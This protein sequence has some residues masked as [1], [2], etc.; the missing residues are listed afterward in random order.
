MV[1]ILL[2]DKDKGEHKTIRNLLEKLPDIDSELHCLTDYGSGLQELLCGQ[3]DLCF[4]ANDLEENRG[5]RFLEDSLAQSIEVPIVILSSGKSRKTDLEALHFGAADFLVKGRIQPAFLQRSIRYALLR[6]ENLR[7]ERQVETQAQFKLSTQ[8]LGEL[9]T[10]L[11]PFLSDALNKLE[12]ATSQNPNP[13]LFSLA[14]DAYRLVRYLEDRFESL[15][16][17]DE[18]F[19]VQQLVLETLDKTRMKFSKDL[20]VTTELP[21]DASLLVSGNSKRLSRALL[22]ILEYIQL[23]NNGG[24]LRIQ[25]SKT[26][27]PTG[28]SC[29]FL[30]LISSAPAPEELIPLSKALQEGSSLPSPLESESQKGLVIAARIIKDMGGSLAINLQ[31]ENTVRFEILFPLHIPAE[32]PEARF[33]SK[34]HSER[35]GLILIFDS[36]V[37]SAEIFEL[38][39][40]AAQLTPKIFTSISEGLEWFSEYSQLV[41]VALI[42]TDFEQKKLEQATRILRHGLPKDSLAF[43]GERSILSYNT[44]IGSATDVYFERPL[45]HADIISWAKK[46]GNRLAPSA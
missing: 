1:R 26:V 23:L 18:R 29:A 43:F 5:I 10:D 27:P 33:I 8:E 46:R 31:R 7:E 36:R 25:A 21:R 22:H 39:L 24:T 41:S 28:P 35:D 42:D 16:S 20:F 13:K 32:N 34:T 37:A 4:V 14:S 45:A 17:H 38:Y 40:Q 30:E 44:N 3:F 15:Q 11:I 12:I 6:Q 19:N 9:T 2:I